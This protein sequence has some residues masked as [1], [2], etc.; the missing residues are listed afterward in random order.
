MRTLTILAAL[1]CISFNAQ[2][3]PPQPFSRAKRIATKLYSDHQESF[4]CGRTYTKKQKK[5]IPDLDSC[6]YEP[7]K[8]AK[9]ANRI[10][11]EHVVPAW[12]F[13]H[14]L[15]CWQD[16]G[17]KN[18]KKNPAFVRMEA[19]LHNLVPAI[20]EANGDRSNYSFAMIEGEPRAYGSCDFEVNFKTRKV[21]PAPEV[22]G[23]IARTYFYMRDEYG[24]KISKKQTQ[25]FIAWNKLDPVDDWEAIRN[26]RITKIQGNTNSYATKQAQAAQPE[27]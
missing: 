1:P 15:Q 18:C 21:E 2:A 26:E 5:L 9:R 12:A 11:W 6:G 23:N 25:L 27:S 24:L 20:G 22:R 16:G 4:Y 10:E 13:G 8:Q 7:R 19:D 17:R 14:Q 3:E